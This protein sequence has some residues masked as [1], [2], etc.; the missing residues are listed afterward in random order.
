MNLSVRTILHQ[1]ADRD[2]LHRVMFRL[3]RNRISVQLASSIRIHKKDFNPK[4]PLAPIRSGCLYAET[5]NSELEKVR[6]RLENMGRTHEKATAAELKTLYL[7]PQAN[8]EISLRSVLEEIITKSKRTERKRDEHRKFFLWMEEYFG[9]PL[10]EKH[11]TR[12]AI[13]E[14]AENRKSWKHVNTRSK[15]KQVVLHYLGELKRRG[16]YSLELPSWE[17]D[18]EK[19]KKERLTEEELQKIIELPCLGNKLH[20]KN[21][22]LLQFY[23]AGMRVADCLCLRFENINGNRLCYE[24]Q[25]NNKSGTML[26]LPQV[27]AI[28]DSYRQERKASGYIL[29]FVKMPLPEDMQSPNAKVFHKHLESCTST[30]NNNLKKIAKL[31]GIEKKLSSHIARHTFATHIK[32]RYRQR[33]E[34]VNIYA[35]QGALR[36][37]SI[38]MTEHYLD[39]LDNDAADEVLR[40]L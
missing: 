38:K 27:Q 9:K 22:F 40:L 32:N 25:K 24:M 8:E 13:D 4:K 3:T 39:E 28:I 34:A 31:C 6:M 14:F 26:I 30:V 19:T 5:Y 11:L 36:H 18:W 7:K 33:G 20:A 15:F 21:C 12:E 17:L 35:L 10:G 29:P 16:L 2:G 37:S 23:F 1:R